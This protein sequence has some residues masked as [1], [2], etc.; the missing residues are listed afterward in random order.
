MINYRRVIACLLVLL[1]PVFQ[2][3]MGE[4]SFREEEMFQPILLTWYRQMGWGT[5]MQV[6]C[7]DDEGGLWFGELE[8]TSNLSLRTPEDV[9]KYFQESQLFTYVGEVNADR[10]M[11]LDS[12]I[13]CVDDECIRE[14]GEA[15]DAGT[16]YSYAICDAENGQEAVL[17]GTSGDR[18]L[19]NANVNAQALY[20]AL[21]ELFPDVMSY[22]GWEG[23]S[24]AVFEPCP[25][26]EFC[27]F[28]PLDT[29]TVSVTASFTD[30]EAGITS[31]LLTRGET[32]ELI[33]RLANML[34]VGKKSALSVTGG[35]TSYVFT[36]K[37][38]DVLGRCAFFDGML[39]QA[40]GIYQVGTA[41]EAKSQM[42]E[43]EL[44]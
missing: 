39:Y 31:R 19:E 12:L 42:D 17:L 33:D 11:E 34:V 9:L 27:K 40:D 7:L 44:P 15:C 25:L 6:G 37:D 21:R 8:N 2:A 22:A 4:A 35:V 29:E 26:M 28:Q 14:V 3:A 1:L 38:G 36:G 43:S 13:Q 23:M 20:F 18:A 24:P 5:R 16:E 32:E 41:A 30:C 10:L